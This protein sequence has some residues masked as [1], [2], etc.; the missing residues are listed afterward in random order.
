ME[1]YNPDTIQYD[2]LRLE[3]CENNS[4]KDS[5]GFSELLRGYLT[6]AYCIAEEDKYKMNL[7]GEFESIQVSLLEIFVT[8][9]SN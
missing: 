3:R 7:R 5:E 1:N 6:N 9:C 2:Y 8:R 4:F